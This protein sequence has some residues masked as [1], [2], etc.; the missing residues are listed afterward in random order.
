MEFRQVSRQFLFDMYKIVSDSIASGQAFRILQQNRRWHN[1]KTERIVDFGANQP[2]FGANTMNFAN[3]G[4]NFQNFAPKLAM[5]IEA[6]IWWNRDN[7]HHCPQSSTS[8]SVKVTLRVHNLVVTSP[9][10][11]WKNKKKCLP[12]R[13]SGQSKSHELSNSKEKNPLHQDKA[14]HQPW[15]KLA[16]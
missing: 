1:R 14:P 4:A 16:K 12:D 8:Q 5:I 3:F 6:V 13:E 7:Q 15:E 10:Y 9:Y 2:Y 11:Y